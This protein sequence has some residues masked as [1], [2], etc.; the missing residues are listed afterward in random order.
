M[1]PL[2]VFVGPQVDVTTD[3]ASNVKTM[4]ENN[5][6]NLDTPIQMIQHAR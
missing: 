6:S 3:E 1:K 5:D 4:G 2:G